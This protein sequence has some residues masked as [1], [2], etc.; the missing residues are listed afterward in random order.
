MHAL[1]RRK[2]Q[3]LKAAHGSQHRPGA[4]KN[5]TGRDLNQIAA[6]IRIMVRYGTG[7]VRFTP[8]SRHVRC[9][10][11]CPLWASGHRWVI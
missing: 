4:A 7:D 6:R 11:P 2:D 10:R 9:T 5:A 3:Q 8:E 1:G